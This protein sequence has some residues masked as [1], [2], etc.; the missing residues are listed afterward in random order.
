MYATLGIAQGSVPESGQSPDRGKTIKV[1]LDGNVEFVNHGLREA[2]G[3][4]FGSDDELFLTDNEGTWVPVNKLM[5][6]PEGEY[7]FY[8]HRD[9]LPASEKDKAHVN[10]TIWL[11]QNEIGNSPTQP[12]VLHGGPYEGQMIHGD[13]THG[14]LKRDFVEKVN[15]QYQGCVF[16]F[17]QGLEVGIMRTARQSMANSSATSC[18]IFVLSPWP[19]SVPPVDT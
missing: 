2:N 16:R 19:I 13:L 1:S 4:G 7:T 3:I 11:V 8:G 14:G 17:A 15:G 9:L 12:I 18:R 10:P 6:A 5:H